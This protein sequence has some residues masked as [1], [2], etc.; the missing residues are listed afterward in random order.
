MEDIQKFSGEVASTKDKAK[1]IEM[2]FSEYGRVKIQL[3][4][5]EMIRHK[6]ENPRLEF[7]KGLKIHFYNTDGLL[8]SIIT[9]DYAERYEEKGET[10]LRNNVVITTQKGETLSTE[11]LLW[12]EKQE[13][14]SSNKL[15][16]IK[17]LREQ[18]TGHNGF[19]AAQDFSRYKLL[20]IKDSKV[21]VPEENFKN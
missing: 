5:A 6:N 10:I 13:K 20:G 3:E 14:I 1:N 15:V 21:I 2:F 17:T 7:P 18:L 4:A 8:Q 16:R 19:E 9:A 12:S 11:E